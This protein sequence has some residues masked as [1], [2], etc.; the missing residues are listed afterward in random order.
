MANLITPGRAAMLPVLA[1]AEPAY[2]V[3]LVSTASELIIRY[4]RRDFVR[5]AYND[6][7]YDGNGSR[8][9]TLR[10]FP[11]LELTEVKIVEH[12]GAEIACDGDNYRVDRDVGEIRPRPDC[13]CD[14]CYFPRGFRNVLVT[15]IAGFDPVPADIQEACAQTAAWLFST[16]SAA[17]NVDAWKLGDASVSYRGDGAQPLPTAIRQMLGPYRNVRA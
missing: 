8:V 17:A 5:T 2:I 7:V 16:G 15:Y 14:Y 6:E 12:D 3:E 13:D 1:D 4:C 10:Q 9:L 11:V